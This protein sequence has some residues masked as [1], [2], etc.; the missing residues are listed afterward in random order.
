[1]V[2]TNDEKDEIH[3]LY[4]FFVF[5]HAVNVTPSPPSTFVLLSC[6]FSSCCQGKKKFYSS[7]TI[8]LYWASSRLSLS[9]YRVPYIQRERVPIML[10]YATANNVTTRHYSRR[11]CVCCGIHGDQQLTLNLKNKNIYFFS[12]NNIRSVAG[13]IRT[14]KGDEGQK[15]AASVIERLVQRLYSTGLDS[16]VIARRFIEGRCTRTP[17]AIILIF[18]YPSFFLLSCWPLQFVDINNRSLSFDVL[19][20]ITDVFLIL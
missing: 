9:L 8:L 10:F 15:R 5:P 11:N 2:A 12:L 16:D 20:Y 6:P 18:V 7:S 3:F 19:G 17:K 14:R 13:I 1:M 4:S